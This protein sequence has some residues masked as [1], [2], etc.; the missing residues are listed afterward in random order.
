M[1][2]TEKNYT[3]KLGNY[4]R[5]MKRTHGSTMC[6][7]HRWKYTIV[8]II[9]MQQYHIKWNWSSLGKVR[10]S[11][12]SVGRSP[13]VSEDLRKCPRC[14]VSETVQ[15]DG[16]M[17][18]L[19]PVRSGIPGLVVSGLTGCPISEINKFKQRAVSNMYAVTH[20]VHSNWSHN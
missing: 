18:R 20:I 13:G 5:R 1:I 17:T 3:S 4:T 8:S 9:Y 6:L 19:T 2:F 16:P 10:S 7:S 12:M 15:C 11:R 14:P